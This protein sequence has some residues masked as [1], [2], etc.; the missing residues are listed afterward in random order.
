VA[1]LKGA[2]PVLFSDTGDGSPIRPKKL[3]TFTGNAIA[4]NPFN[5]YY[6]VQAA[7]G[8]AFVLA[9]QLQR[10]LT[11]V[12]KTRCAAGAE[13]TNNAQLRVFD[14]GLTQVTFA[15]GESLRF[16]APAAGIYVI[17]ADYGVN[18]GMLNASRL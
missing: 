2:A 17:R 9:V 15:C 4:G 8:D 13:S 18:G 10:P 3:S 12:Q 1:S 11:E 7:Q 14:A 16:V 6:W 5:D